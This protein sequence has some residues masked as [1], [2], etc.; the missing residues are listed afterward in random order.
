MPPNKKRITSL[1]LWVAISFGAAGAGTLIQSSS[2]GNW[3]E[4][5]TYDLRFAMRGSL[6]PS[7]LAPTT[8]L[9]IDE[10]TLSEIPDPLMLWH[11]HFASVIEKLAEGGAAVVGIDFI[12]S[13][14]SLFDPAGQQSLSQA[15]L[16]AGP[17][18]LPV[19][20]A[21]RVTPYGVEQPPEA[22]RFAALAV[23]HSLAYVNLTTDSDDFVRSQEIAAPSE[24]DLQPSFPL[25]IASA[26]AGKT[27]RTLPL[28]VDSQS[29]ILVNFRGPDHFPRIPFS[30][31]V[32][33]AE[34]GDSAWFE[35]NFAGRIVL[36]GRIGE[37]GDED[38]HATPQY[39]WTDRTDVTRAWRTPGIEIHGS[40][41]ATL[42]EGGF[43]RE[44]EGTRQF[45]AALA[46][47]A[48]VTLLSLRYP[49][50]WAI[51]S[52]ILALFAFIYLAF[53]VLFPD[54]YWLH[55]VAPITGSALAAGSAQVANYVREGRQ[56][57]YL[58]SVFRRYVNDAVIEEILKSPD[59]LHLEGERK[60]ISVLFADI[61]SFTTRSE[62]LEAEELV[63][64]LNEYFTEM[65]RAIQSRGGMV[66]KFIGDGIMALFGAPL[67]DLDAPRHSVEAALAMVEAL[68]RVNQ[69]LAENGGE[70]IRIGIGIHTGDAVVGNMGSPEKMD[71]T[72]IGDV[73]NTASRIESL[74]RR[75]D[76]DILISRETFEAA[77]EGIQ[78]THRG[79]EEVKG[80]AKPVEVYEVLQGRKSG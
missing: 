34:E 29:T 21:Y 6:P 12:F 31:A 79:S 45:G 65:V 20:L 68:D 30:A 47:I 32:Q 13:D 43:I 51:P 39:F 71:Y 52:S 4:Q 15:L 69:K 74:T 36:I 14:I 78:A 26:Y 23:G 54:G 3:V 46:L 77:G 80:K 48:L 40:T 24:G 27:D 64:Q 1:A 42:I 53:S 10:P 61:R 41:I 7:T 22:V 70:P 5:R 25:A 62:G 63:G 37:R 66:D 50:A 76:T 73:V 56:K 44:I 67:Q 16:R 2:L 75:L 57:K 58:R 18:G 55:L 72:A 28:D 33:A 49:P 19:V 59:G 17:A 38:F 35:E 9:A 8:I 60:R 11:R